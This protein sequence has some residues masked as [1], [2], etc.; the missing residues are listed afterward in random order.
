MKQNFKHSFKTER[1]L[2]GKINEM[3]GIDQDTLHHLST[4]LSFLPSFI[5]QQEKN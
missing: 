1:N 2:L 5:H 3:I 4:A